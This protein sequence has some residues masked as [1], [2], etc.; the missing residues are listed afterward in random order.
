MPRKTI[1][2]LQ[3]EL[4]QS[5]GEK[6]E[7][8]SL[9]NECIEELGNL[10]RYAYKK[11]PKQIAK[12]KELVNYLEGRDFGQPWREQNNRFMYLLRVALGDET[13]KLDNMTEEEKSRLASSRNNI[14]RMCD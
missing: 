3:K 11:I 2:G 10:E 9:L 4:S 12:L 13:L 14:N 8:R 1:A 5:E 7:L 6:N